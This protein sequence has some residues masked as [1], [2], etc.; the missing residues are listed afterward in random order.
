MLSL[1][2]KNKKKKFN[3]E[4]GNNQRKWNILAKENYP[5]IFS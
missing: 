2:V 1:P 3:N 5:N 4:L